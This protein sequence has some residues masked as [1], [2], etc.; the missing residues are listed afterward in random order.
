MVVGSICLGGVN[1]VP[2]ILLK[3]Q[4]MKPRIL[5]IDKIAYSIL[6]GIIS[7]KEEESSAL[8]ARSQSFAAPS[9][10]ARCPVRFLSALHTAHAVS[11][12]LISLLP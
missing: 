5:P 4:T 9:A 8:I 2:F 11:H 6:G 10:V 3:W 7:F 1:A 12:T